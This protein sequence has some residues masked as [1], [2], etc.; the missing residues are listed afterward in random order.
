MQ[1]AICHE[2][3][4]TLT[5]QMNAQKYWKT[6]LWFGVSLALVVSMYLFHHYECDVVLFENSRVLRHVVTTTNDVVVEKGTVV[7]FD[8]FQRDDVF[9]GFRTVRMNTSG[10][11]PVTCTIPV[12][13]GVDE[14][15]VQE[16][17]AFDA[18]FE[19]EITR[20]ETS[21]LCA[22]H[23]EEEDRRLTEVYEEDIVRTCTN[24]QRFVIFE[25]VCLVGCWLFFVTLDEK[26]MKYSLSDFLRDRK[27]LTDLLKSYDAS[28]EAALQPNLAKKVEEVRESV[29]MQ[30]V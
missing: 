16:A 10:G 19:T 14:K 25:I 9:L 20:L 23:K 8:M 30:E 22:E 11:Y 28:L 5:K 29:L 12:T 17:T 6:G 1:E 7:D 26:L 24:L 15:L 27:D 4:R 21:G 13:S 18:P 3:R 2:F